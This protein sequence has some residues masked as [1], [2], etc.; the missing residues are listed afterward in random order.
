LRGSDFYGKRQS[1]EAAADGRDRQEVVGGNLRAVEMQL[2][3]RLEKK[4]RRPKRGKP[5][6]ARRIVWR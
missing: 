2:L 4:C 3:V 5:I 1:I 6:D